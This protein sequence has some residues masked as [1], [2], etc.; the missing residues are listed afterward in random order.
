MTRVEFT[1]LGEPQPQGSKTVIQQKGR[2]PRM[3][4]DNP[5][6]EPWRHTVAARATAAMNGRQL[7]TGPLRLR[8]TFVFAR[9]ASHFGTGRNEGRLKASAPLYVRKR[10]D[11]DKLLRAIGDALTGIVFRDD[12]QIVDVRAEKHFGGQPCA[13]IVVDELAVEDDRP[14]DEG[15]LD[16]RC[17]AT[18]AMAPLRPRTRPRRPAPLGRHPPQHVSSRVQHPR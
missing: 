6:T 3:I 18:E 11:V 4:E 5:M 16:G 17:D 15:D 13:H 8:A 7:R 10:P 14:L 1:V 9:P 2:R 12:A